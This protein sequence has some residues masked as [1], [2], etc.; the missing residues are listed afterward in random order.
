MFNGVYRE[1]VRPERLVQTFEFEG[2]PGHVSIE[3]CKLEEVNGKTRM[4]I[5]SLF[6][7]VE[8]RDGTLASGMEKGATETH[9]PL[10]ELLEKLSE[11]RGP[12]RTS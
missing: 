1:V 3:T 9:D 7:T 8:D 10:A 5:T 12:T 4:T 11:N 6:R 2:M